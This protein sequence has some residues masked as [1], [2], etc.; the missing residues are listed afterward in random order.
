MNEA[1]AQLHENQSKTREIDSQRYETLMDTET[2][3]FR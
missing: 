1:E 3:K 2:L